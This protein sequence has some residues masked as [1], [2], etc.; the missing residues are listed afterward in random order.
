MLQISLA[1]K[2]T[3]HKMS[4]YLDSGCSR[5]MTGRRSTFQDLVLKPGGEVN[6]GGDQKGEIIGS[7]TISLGNSPSIT[8]VLLVEELTHNLL[9]I[10]QLSGNGYD[11]IFNQKSCKAVS[12]K[13]DSILFIGKRKNNIYKIDLS[14]LEK[15]KVTCLMS[16]SEEQWVWHRRLGH[17]SLRK[18]SLI[19]KLDLVRGLPNLKYKSDA[20]CEACQKGKFSKPAFKSK[21]VVSS[22]RPLELL[23]IDLFGPVKIASIRGKKYGLVIVEDYSR[24]TWVKFLKHKD[25]SHSVFFEFC[26][27]IQ[28]E[29]ECKI[30]KVRSDHGGE[31]ENKF[32]EEFFKEN[33]IAHDFSCPR[34]PQENAVVERKNRTLQEMARTMINETNMAKHFWAE[35]INSVCYIQNRISIR[36]ILNKTPYELW[37]N[38]KPNISY[39]HPF[40][41]VCFIMNTKDHLGKF[42][43]KAQKCFLLG[44]SERSK[45]YRVYNT[46]TLIVEESINIRFDD[47]LGLEKLKQF[48]NFADFDI[49]ISEAVEPRSKAA[50]DDS[51]RSNESEDQVAASLENLRISEEPTVRRSPRLASAHSEDVILGK[52]DDPIRTRAFLKNDNQMQ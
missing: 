51:L 34:T 6:F 42:D 8:N 20:L 14:D 10:S 22:S 13:D 9:S 28:S 18:I 7:G 36:P 12:Q 49:D 38:R 46:E 47:K 24:W 41:C 35:A 21:N 33:G 48:E 29:K 11:M 1:A 26:T 40:G 32:F 52:K 16:V 45:G 31:F 44:Y 19:N 27:Q 4:W 15:Q 2:R 43:S 5:H 3:K 39:F 23:H 17:A 30:I 37:K 50:E 25:E